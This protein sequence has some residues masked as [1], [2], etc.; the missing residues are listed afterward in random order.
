VKYPPVPVQTQI[1]IRSIRRDKRLF[2]ARV[3]NT[4]GCGGGVAAPPVQPRVLQT[5]SGT[6]ATGNGSL[7]LNFP[8]T[9]SAGSVVVFTAFCSGTIGLA[10]ATFG[11]VPAAQIENWTAST[12]GVAGFGNF[13]PATA[14]TNTL[15][16]T[17]GSGT[18]FVTGYAYEV[19]GIT[20]SPSFIGPTY[21]FGSDVAAAAFIGAAGAWTSG[22]ATGTSVIGEFW[23]GLGADFAGAMAGTSPGWRQLP[24]ITD[25]ASNVVVSGYTVTTGGPSAQAYTGTQSSFIQQ[26]IAE[27][28]GYL[29]SPPLTAAVN[30]GAVNRRRPGTYGRAAAGNSSA[31]GDGF[32]VSPAAQASTG[33]ASLTGA[34]AVTATGQ[35]TAPAVTGGKIGRRARGTYGR[36][37]T[38]NNAA[39]G[40]GVAAPATIIAAAAL[41]GAGTLTAAGT[42]LAAA[43]VSGVLFRRRLGMYGRGALGNKGQPGG[44]V[45]APPLPPPAVTAGLVRR[46][47][48]ARAVTAGFAAGGLTHGTAALTGAGALT[49]SG[50][51][52][53]PAATAGLVRCR[54]TGTYGR[55]AAGSAGRCGSGFAAGGLVY[56]AAALTGAGALTA[57]GTVPTVAPAGGLVRRRAAGTYGRAVTGP[58]SLPADGRAAPATTIGTAVLTGAGALTAAGTTTVTAVTGGLVRRRAAGTYGRAVTGNTARPGS[59]LA[60]PLLFAGTASLTGAGAVTAAGTSVVLTAPPLW[61]WT[62][63]HPTPPRA[64]WRGLTVP[65][66]PIIG[67]AALTGAGTLTAAGHLLTTAA[68]GGLVR[69]R[70][71][72]RA[73]TGNTARPGGG[74]A[75]P[76]IF[77]GAASL[78]GAGS[79]TAAGAP[80]VLTALPL[81]RW[82]ARHPTPSR[83]LWRGLTV[84]PPAVTA[85]AALAG[86][87]TLAAAGT[88]LAPA[89][90]ARF[91]ILPP[92]RPAAR[93]VWRGLAAPAPVF[94]VG[95]A[96]LTGAGALTAAGTALGA[97]RAGGLV[98]RRTTARAA[99]GNTARPGGGYPAPGFTTATAALTGAGTLTAAGTPFA[100]PVT[101]SRA[102]PPRRGPAR[103]VWRGV[104]GPLTFTG[105]ATL[106]GAGTLFAA[107]SSFSP[108]ATGGLVRRRGAA[109]AVW[110]GSPYIPKYIPSSAALTGAGTLTAA[111]TVLGATATGGLVRRRPAA[112]A[113][114]RQVA[115]PLIFAAAA[116]LTGAGT[117]TAAGTQ[118]AP[119]VTGGLL[120]RR[121]AGR[122]VTGARGRI[123]GGGV[124]GPLLLAGTVSLAGA[125]TV[126]AAG[127]VLGAVTTGG[128]VRR[129]ATG[130]YG[131][132][133]AGA[134]AQNWAGGAGPVTY[135]GTAALTGAGTL[136]AVSTG[137]AFPATG[138]LVRRRRAARAVWRGS[139]PGV[140][141]IQ[142]AAA[143]TGAGTLTAAGHALGGQPAT[144]GLVR[145]RT[146]ARVVWR[147]AAGAFLP[148]TPPLPPLAVRR[149]TPSRVLWRGNPVPAGAIFASAALTGAGTLT[150]AGVV[151]APPL[152][153][154]PPVTLTVAQTVPITVTAAPVAP[155]T[156]TVDPVTPVTITVFPYGK[157]VKP[158]AQA[159]IPAPV[160][161]TFTGAGVLAASAALLAFPATGGLVRRR[162]TGTYG[163]AATGPGGRCGA[164]SA[165]GGLIFGAAALTGAG[166][167]KAAGVTVQLIGLPPLSVKRPAPGRARVGGAAGCGGGNAAPGAVYGTAALTG[168]GTLTAVWSPPG[169]RL[170]AA[171]S[172]PSSS[173]SYTGPFTA[174]ILFQVT[175]PGLNLDGYWIW[176]ADAAQSA[177]ASFALWH[178]TG[179][180]GATYL[181]AATT[182]TT[183]ALV[184]G[185]WNYVQLATPYPLTAGTEYEA[186][187][188]FPNNFPI[189]TF[190]FGTGGPYAGGITSGPI[191][192]FSDTA[193]NGGT[194]PDAFGNSQG[195]F[196]TATSDPT[197]TVPFAGFDSSNF[198]ID[199]QI[200]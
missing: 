56:A 143:I 48:A 53:A 71:A 165:A 25:G 13:A 87:G 189:T 4:G 19:T 82:T 149:P 100:S 75:G 184:A 31:C 22:T 61:R 18:A 178:V 144:G 157:T 116:S 133:A 110:R 103:A 128:L 95:V 123:G 54:P 118:T 2:R 141:I 108:T 11:G 160:A 32:A 137:F 45:A 176:R 98:R 130:T 9:V 185:Q 42:V 145:R 39:C 77:A 86:A 60:G 111:G 36:A 114:T 24:G 37:V 199:V 151:E 198:W 162:T 67:A 43:T 152:P 6:S 177:S 76:L 171:A 146:T 62:A 106:T 190:Q 115:G 179:N 200:S 104:A 192:A 120:R 85:T 170:F 29:S 121:A 64:L 186:V 129:R 113:V 35:V 88:P 55:G 154:L 132:G 126:T 122:A 78:T 59:G 81:W 175:S 119:A 163:R 112:R 74:L 193:A 191:S 96:S 147:G 195:V 172:G 17:C 131:R 70:P 27:V 169:N 117:V 148:L 138:G 91:P 155:V 49:A 12:S 23:V 136:F 156:V 102:V 10:S 44:G 94:A 3:G 84:P 63:R 158:P 57:S 127:T 89:P 68:T 124:T 47:A 125:G 109:R 28:I 139:G 142:A 135:I 105:T 65:P 52:L 101:G 83:V 33:T 26:G 15:V 80:V 181:G 182:V 153:P 8:H 46:R 41:T 5:A 90:P 7:T 174:G 150:A 99:A 161:K 73:V 183:A 166:T 20:L 180:D 168:A 197:V 196:A 14:G 34:G 134:K 164:G 79:L 50:T 93:A 72:A 30:S 194:N 69:R 40:D 159:V 140:P 66:P 167:V 187:Y 1:S 92:R 38:G 58:R 188:G 107:P 51:L 173:T 21:E 97:A 16:L